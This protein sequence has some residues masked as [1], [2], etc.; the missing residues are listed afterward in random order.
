MEAQ[1][2]LGLRKVICDGNLLKLLDLK[3][4]FAA[5]KEPGDLSV[6]ER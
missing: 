5:M 1:I 3:F 6:P 2:I 4:L